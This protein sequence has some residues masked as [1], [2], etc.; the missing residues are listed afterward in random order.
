[1]YVKFLN[2]DYDISGLSFLSSLH[3]HLEI[4]TTFQVIKTQSWPV[5]N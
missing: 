2:D 3:L 1:M 5:A 4:L